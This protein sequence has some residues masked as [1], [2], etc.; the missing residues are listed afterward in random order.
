MKAT[1]ILGSNLSDR[2]LNLQKALEMLSKQMELISVSPV[3]ETQSI[4]FDG[5]DF[6]NQAAV[7]ETELNPFELLKLCKETERAIG[8]SDSPEYDEDGRRIYHN[9]LIDID[10][11]ECDDMI[12]N[13]PE[14]ILPHP[15]KQT[16]PYVQTL[17][18]KLD[19]NAQ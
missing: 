11:L 3:M 8:R 13:N 10:I 16:R 19:S 15:Q 7:F 18:D 5:F 14:L 2:E 4:G 6:L 12:V 1:L 17:L 9:R